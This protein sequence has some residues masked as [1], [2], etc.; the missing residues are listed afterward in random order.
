[1]GFGEED[2][3]E[4]LQIMPQTNLILSI[5][6]ISVDLFM[7]VNRSTSYLISPNHLRKLIRSGNDKGC[8]LD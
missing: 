7:R 3:L 8:L 2:K 1:M 5:Y 4:L 6:N